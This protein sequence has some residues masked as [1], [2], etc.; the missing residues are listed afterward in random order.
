MSRNL[1]A[2]LAAQRGLTVETQ[3]DSW[4]PS[5]RHD[6][7]AYHDAITVCRKPDGAG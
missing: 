5:G 6:L 3:L 2:T 4:G 7:S 1:F